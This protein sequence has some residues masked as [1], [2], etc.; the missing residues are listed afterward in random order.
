[1]KAVMG[2][3]VVSMLLS[4]FQ[5]GADGAA[6]S[7][8][9]APEYGADGSLV[10]PADYREW[11]FLTSSLDM[12]YSKLAMPGMHHMFDNVFVQAEA[13]HA[14][15]QTGQWPD[16]TLIV[17]EPRGAAS[18]GSINQRGHFQTADLM[19]LELHLKDGAR[20]PGGWAFFVT[21][22]TAPAQRIP[23]QA[24]CYTCHRGHG[25]VDSTFVQFYPTLLPVARKL[26]TLSPAFLKE[27]GEHR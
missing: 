4:P 26:G 6:A 15:L 1:M 24:D 19:G 8:L 10:P 11:I 12:D 22:G 16:H 21:D 14:F 20:F 3:A 5:C 2:V 9:K 17:K 25:A 23:E 27:S 7:S 13:Y 18:K